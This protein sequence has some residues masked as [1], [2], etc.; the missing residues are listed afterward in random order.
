M[1]ACTSSIIVLNCII[2]YRKE[3]ED[4][5]FNMYLFILFVS[6][7]LFYLLLIVLM[8]ESD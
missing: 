7:S 1:A 6:D 8:V 5:D 3:E 2:M 4:V